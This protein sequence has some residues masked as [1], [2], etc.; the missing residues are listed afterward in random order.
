MEQQE[1]VP[2]KKKRK[3]AFK[4]T[5]DWASLIRN[6]ATIAASCISAITLFILIR[7]NERTYQPDL[8]LSPD[9]GIFQIAYRDTIKYCEDLR[10]VFGQDSSGVQ[11]NLRVINLGLGAARDL[12]ITWDYDPNR[13]DDTVAIGS[14]R[15]PTNLSYVKGLNSLMFRSCLM[16]ENM[17]DQLEYCLPFNAEKE[18]T[19]TSLPLN[20]VRLWSNLL[21]RIGVSSEMPRERR[22]KLVEQLAASFQ[23]LTC[24][25][26]YFDINGREY[27]KSYIVRI[28]P[29]FVDLRNRTL[30]LGIGLAEQTDGKRKRHEHR[31]RIYEPDASFSES[32][33]E[34]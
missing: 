33:V 30:T 8:V 32:A 21:T 11:L 7:Q 14:F 28:L 6:F 27:R 1:P 15:I 4:K 16:S 3:T 20:Y 25:I 22:I 24:N 9:P 13:L 10:I 5:A 2:E 12:D 26:H 18:A 17:G 31:F 29:H 34:W 19:L 23:D